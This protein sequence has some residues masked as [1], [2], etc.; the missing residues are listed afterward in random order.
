MKKSISQNNQAMLVCAKL[1]S[2]LIYKMSILVFDIETIPDV[3][4]GRK[5]YDLQDLSDEDTVSALSALRRLKVGNDFLPHYL[6]KVVAISLV[7][8]QGSQLKVWSLGDEQS[9]EKDLIQRFF[10]GV[11]KYTPTLVSWNG[12]GFDLPVLHY[13]S[14]LHGI[15][16]PTYWENGENHQ[17]F[18]WNN[19]LNRF[20]Y[21]HLDLMD[22]LAA[23]QN[24]A[25]APLDEIASMLGFPGKMG[26]SGAKVWDEYSQGNLKKIRDYCE[27]DVLN[28][29]CV[30]LRFELMRGALNQNEYANQIENLR[31]Y[32]QSQA[33]KNHLQEFLQRMH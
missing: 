5:L 27:T 2:T 28:T 30:Y 32:L 21:R 16:A 24:K 13:R 33:D 7:L 31:N 22:I 3:E 14:L 11:E 15:S 1:L 29:Y 12:C 6:Q 9:D 10:S 23:Y 17:H 25:F 18:R 4:A 19:Y 26:M 20:H 8:S